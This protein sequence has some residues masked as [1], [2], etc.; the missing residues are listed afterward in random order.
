M[1]ASARRACDSIAEL[2]AVSGRL[3]GDGDSASCSADSPPRAAASTC[4]LEVG[5]CGLAQLCA[6]DAS[7][8]GG[9]RGAASGGCVSN[10]IEPRASPV[11]LSRGAQWH[12]S[13]PCALSRNRAPARRAQA[14]VVV[15]RSM[16][17]RACECAL[18][19]PHADSVRVSSGGSSASSDGYKPA[20]CALAE[21]RADL[22]RL[23]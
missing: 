5:V 16:A 15:A 14:A 11:R 9:G 18:T 12:V 10:V 13:P 8:S 19:E 20:T 23:R 6:L 22:M 2:R 1:A 17:V 21:P 3:R 4:G 7:L